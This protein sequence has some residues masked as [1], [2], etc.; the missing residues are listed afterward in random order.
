[1]DLNS[2]Q[3]D[4]ARHCLGMNYTPRVERNYYC[5]NIGGTGYDDWID[6]VDKGYA[7][8]FKRFDNTYF[9]IKEDYI[10]Y[11]TDGVYDE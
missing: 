2:I 1:M 10:K 5:I 9:Y 11:I 8:S 3:L 6:M 4:M 7:G